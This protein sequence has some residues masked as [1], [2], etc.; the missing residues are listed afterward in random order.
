MIEQKFKLGEECYLYRNGGIEKGKIAL[1]R[2][3]LNEEETVIKY[4]IARMDN[5][6]KYAYVNQKELFK[7]FE[8][9]KNYLIEKKMKE[10]ERINER[11]KNLKR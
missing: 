5:T 2:L 9:A 10:I 7:T 4:D 8:D 3:D 11:I 1:A 6:I